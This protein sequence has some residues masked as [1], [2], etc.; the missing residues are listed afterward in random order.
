MYNHELPLDTELVKWYIKR[1]SA[2]ISSERWAEYSAEICSRLSNNMH[3][4]M[5][6]LESCTD[7]ELNDLDDELIDIIEEFQERPGEGVFVEFFWE[8]IEIRQR[9]ELIENLQNAFEAIKEATQWD[10]NGADNE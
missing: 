6:F 4:T 8:L 2:N 7:E 5:D 3:Q 1:K 9:S 10:E